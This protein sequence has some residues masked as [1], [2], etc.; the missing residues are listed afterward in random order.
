MLLQK[1]YIHS[2]TYIPLHLETDDKVEYKYR[3]CSPDSANLQ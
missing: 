1:E 2:D 3:F